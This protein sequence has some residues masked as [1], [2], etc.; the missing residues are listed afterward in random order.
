MQ[1]EGAFVRPRPF[2][3]YYRKLKNKRAFSA[4]SQTLDCVPTTPE[5]MPLAVVCRTS[6]IHCHI[7]IVAR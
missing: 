5:I 2:L 1:R 3:P 4:T 6:L 7:D